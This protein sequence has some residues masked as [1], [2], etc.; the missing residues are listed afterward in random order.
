MG[1]GTYIDLNQTLFMAKLAI[2]SNIYTISYAISNAQI[3]QTDMFVVT[4]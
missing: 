2:S 1:S 4:R 3:G